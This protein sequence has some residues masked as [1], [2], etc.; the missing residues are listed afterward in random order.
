M[1]NL[2]VKLGHCF[3]HSGVFQVTSH[4]VGAEVTCL[5]QVENIVI[6]FPVKLLSHFLTIQQSKQEKCF[7]LL[8]TY[9]TH[10][11]RVA[12]CADK[13]GFFGV[14][15]VSVLPPVFPLARST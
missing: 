10:Q 2:I 12:V 13:L 1:L 8:P 15:M 7:V 14:H 9:S 5:L 6:F 11:Q 4:N 3:A